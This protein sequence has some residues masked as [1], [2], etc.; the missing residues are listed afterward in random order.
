[1]SAQ[2]LRISGMTCDHCARSIEQALTGVSG[3][4]EAKVSYEEGLATVE[5]AS[6][7]PVSMLLDAVAAKGFGA[8][9]FDKT[10]S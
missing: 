3:V 4:T 6:P 5:T 2:A 8:E 1:M 10:P 9:P 7:V